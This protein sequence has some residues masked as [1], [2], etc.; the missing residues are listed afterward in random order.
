MAWRSG[1]SPNSRWRPCVRI[2]FAAQDR[3][4]PLHERVFVPTANSPL[5][6]HQHIADRGTR[7]CT[8]RGPCCWRRAG[9]WRR[10]GRHLPLS[11]R[12]YSSLTVPAWLRVSASSSV[13]TAGDVA[14]PSQMEQSVDVRGGLSQL[15]PRRSPLE[16]DGDSRFDPSRRLL[17][18]NVPPSEQANWLLSVTAPSRGGAAVSIMPPSSGSPRNAARTAAG[19]R[20]SRSLMS[21][22]CEC[23]LRSNSEAS[24][25]PTQTAGF[26]GNATTWW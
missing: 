20:S 11:S 22:R 14:A 6:A 23:S 4:R 12:G 18:I 26:S 15:V 2:R 21:G 25:M 19:S 13:A 5:P 9:R 7:S 10:P 1:H 17:E 8:E 16:V 3:R 24:A